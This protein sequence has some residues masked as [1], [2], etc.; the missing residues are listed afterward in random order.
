[1]SGSFHHHNFSSQEER[2]VWAKPKGGAGWGGRDMLPCAEDPETG[3]VLPLPRPEVGFVFDL[4]A[5]FEAEPCPGTE[6]EQL[7]G[8]LGALEGDA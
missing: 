5:G 7:L 3:L 8:R 4:R 1:M 6:L 2:H